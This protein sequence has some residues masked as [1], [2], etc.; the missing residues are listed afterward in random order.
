MQLS[1]KLLPEDHRVG[2]EKPLQQVCP[3]QCRSQGVRVSVG[4]WTVIAEGG[5][6]GDCSHR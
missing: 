5:A 6:A 4:N 1:R 2:I 3:A